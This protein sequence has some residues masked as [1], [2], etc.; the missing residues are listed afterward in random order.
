MYRNIRRLRRILFW[1]ALASAVLWLIF[2]ETVSIWVPIIL[3]ASWLGA[4]F[5]AV[6]HVRFTRRDGWRCPQCEWVPYAIAAW[7]CKGCGLRWDTFS[8]L[9][10]CPRCGHQH[11]ETACPRC[12]RVS[13]NTA[14]MK[15]LA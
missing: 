10:L 6:F 3:A 7:K 11:E 1:A 14:W 2:P 9:G 13:P 5:Y 8:T 4:L 12:R 15:G